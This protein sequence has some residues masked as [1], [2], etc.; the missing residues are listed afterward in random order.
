MIVFP[1]NFNTSLLRFLSKELL[2][3]LASVG[4]TLPGVKHSQIQHYSATA[5]I[6]LQCFQ[7]PAA[8][9]FEKIGPI[10]FLFEMF[11]NINLA[12]VS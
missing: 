10:V 6:G 2:K 1:Q 7:I 9:H 3:K 4:L 11:E 5:A 12:F 8:V